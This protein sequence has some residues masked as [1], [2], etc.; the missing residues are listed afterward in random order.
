MVVLEHIFFLE[1]QVC[2][3]VVVTRKA[4][5]IWSYSTDCQV[6]CGLKKTTVQNIFKTSCHIREILLSTACLSYRPLVVESKHQRWVCFT[7]ND[8]KHNTYIHTTMDIWVLHILPQFLPQTSSL[9]KCNQNY[10]YC[11]VICL[12][13]EYNYR[14]VKEVHMLNKT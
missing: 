13:E 10:N 14:T 2:Q 7:S 5:S 9:W 11:V 3:S 6:H 8:M 12:R 1:Q 4:Y